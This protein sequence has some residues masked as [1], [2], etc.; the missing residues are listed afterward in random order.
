MASTRT[1]RPGPRD[2]RLRIAVCNWR[3]LAHPRAGGAEVYAQALARRW[4]ALGHEVDLLCAAVPGRPPVEDRDG[5]RILR[6]GSRLTVYREARHALAPARG[7]DLVLECVNTKP[8]DIARRLPHLPVV[9]LVHQ[10]AREVWDYEVPFPASVAGR[11]FLEPRWLS[12][13]SDVPAL[14]ISESSR[15]SLLAAGLRDVTVVPVGVDVSS[16]GDRPP[17]AASPTLAFCGRL[18]ASKRPDHAIAAFHH[19]RRVHPDARLVVI[20]TGPLEATLREAAGAG[21]EFVGRA[22]HA[23]KLALMARAHALVVTSVREGWGLVV[24]EAA[25]V[26]TPAAV[27]DVPGLRDSAAAGRGRV[28]HADPASLADALIDALPGWMDRPPP[29]VPWGGATSWD[30][31]ADEVLDRALDALLRSRDG[32]TRA[33]RAPE[34]RIA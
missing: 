31:A 4:S 15:L 22:D 24:S 12:R 10:L 18:V 9:A 23:T 1:D 32:P 26:G 2:A 27:Y 25:A 20:G 33:S 14:T 5:Y 16:L 30:D 13:M 19:V 11:R 29:P 34:R 3:D 8:F 6:G 7:L 21:V 17:K 28:C